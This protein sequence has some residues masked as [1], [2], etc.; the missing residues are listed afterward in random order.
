MQRRYFRTEGMKERI[1]NYLER[2]EQLTTM[3]RWQRNF[4][5]RRL[6]IMRVYWNRFL[7][8]T[9]RDVKR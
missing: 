6:F 3:Q 5:R 4:K 9:N 2:T 1:H 7:E 8:D